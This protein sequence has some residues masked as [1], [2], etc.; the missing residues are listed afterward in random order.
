MLALV[1]PVHR[2]VAGV[3]HFRLQCR[4]AA[5]ISELVQRGAPATRK[6][7]GKSRKP[8]TQIATSHPHKVPSDKTSDFN[9][10]V[11]D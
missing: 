11:P 10:A 6:L 1:K 8:I 3:I 7:S 5:V 4:A 9:A 2:L